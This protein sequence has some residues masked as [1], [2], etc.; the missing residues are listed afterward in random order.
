MNIVGDA[1][2]VQNEVRNTSF[3]IGWAR[4]D[5]DKRT[6]TIVDSSGNVIDISGWTLSMAVNLE[7]NP[8]NTD[9][10]IFQV[11]GAFVTDGTDGQIAFNPPANSLDNIEAPGEAFYDINRSVPEKKTLLKARVVFEM[12]VDKS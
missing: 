7:R 8:A 5:D 12:D 2:T 4:G 3:D 6:F 11:A 9:N 10:E 1:D